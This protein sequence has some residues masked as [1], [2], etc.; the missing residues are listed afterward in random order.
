MKVE[1]FASC[2]LLLSLPL[3]I[4]QLITLPIFLSVREFRNRICFRVMF[5]LGVAD[6][7]QLLITI[8]FSFFVLYD[9]KSGATFERICGAVMQLSWDMVIFHHLLLAT[10]R[11][12]IFAKASLM[13]SVLKKEP[14]SERILFNTLLVLIWAFFVALVI[15]FQTPNLGVTFLRDYVAFFSD[16]SFPWMGTFRLCEFYWSCLLPTIALIAY[17][18]IV[19]LLKKFRKTSSDAPHMKVNEKKRLLNNQEWRILGQ[20]LATFLMM[21]VLIAMWNLMDLLTWVPPDEL[22]LFGVFV[23]LLFCGMN[24]ILNLA[25]LPEFRQHFFLLYCGCLAITPSRPAAVQSTINVS[26]SVT[27]VGGVVRPAPRKMDQSMA[28]GGRTTNIRRNISLHPDD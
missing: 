15:A 9:F 2:Q 6:S 8:I 1:L 5:C 12:L 24:P 28:N 16:Q 7:L 19:F 26:S 21:S 27:I 14:K 20:S 11:L 18:S 23:F 17:I 10:N 25:N 4:L 22:Q 3:L 13:P